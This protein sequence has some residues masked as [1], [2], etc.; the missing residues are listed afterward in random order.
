M[1]QPQNRTTVVTAFLQAVVEALGQGV[2]MNENGLNLAVH[3]AWGTLTGQPV[4]VNM[5]DDDDKEAVGQVLA[6]VPNTD[7]IWRAAQV[8]REEVPEQDMTNTPLSEQD[9]EEAKA[10]LDE[11]DL[12]GDEALGV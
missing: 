2:E 3:L 6:L 11:E 12:E 1:S 7:L 9:V 5:L 4:K 10:A 8:V